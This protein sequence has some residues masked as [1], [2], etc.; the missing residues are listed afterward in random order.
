[1]DNKQIYNSENGNPWIGLDSYKE[2]QTLYGRSR[3]IQDLSMA[4]FY[5]R[6]TVVYG[7]SG[8][9]K[10]SLLHAGIFPKAR[11]RGCLP[12]SIRFDHSA[13]I[14]YREQLIRSIADAVI[15]NGGELNDL[16]GKNTEPYS[17]WEFFH[18]YQLKRGEETI[19]PL[20]V[21]DQFEEIFTL[22]RNQQQVKDF[23]EELADL[24]ND[25][26]PAYLQ[27]TSEPIA[28]KSSGSLFDN[29]NIQISD[30]L[31]EQEMPFHLV[32]VLREDYLSYLERYSSRTPSLKQN[33]FGLL[34]ITYLQALEIITKPREGLVTNEVA[35]TIIRHIVTENDIT[36]ET[37]VDSA[38]LSL[39]LNRLYEKKNDA[40]AITRQLV[41]EYGNALLEDF[42]AEIAN[43]LDGRTIHYLEDT[44][45]NSDGHRENVSLES[46]YRYDYIK[47]PVIEVLEHNHLLRIFS[48]GNVQRVEFAH[49]VLCPIIVRRRNQRQYA[50]RTRRTKRVG[51]G[52]FFGLFLLLFGGMYIIAERL[53]QKEALA[54]QQERLSEMEVS[55][56]EKGTDKM[57]DN[58]DF[59]GAIR[60]LINSMG[61]DLSNPS[62]S[63][64]RKELEL[65]VA[66]YWALF[67]QDTCVA[68]V[69][70]QFSLPYEKTAVISSSKRL[71]GINDNTG[72]AVIIDSHTGAI[73][74][75]LSKH[76]VNPYDGVFAQ[77]NA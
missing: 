9:G 45:I 58:Y 54:R 17:L 34:P 42:Y 43:P 76:K 50:E 23:F 38:I 36:D 73:V 72:V 3:E 5:N 22:G 66:A 33:R 61:E 27:T 15:D 63:T 7:R 30:S 14:A 52:A 16:T 48:Y 21:I 41:S 20:I 31:Y 65:R 47:R 57:L 71:I 67:S 8:I 69:N 2:G 77:E 4:V 56:I 60:L 32:F 1:M 51:L 12:I 26:K 29:L 70:Y 18:Y 64:A 68:K 24:L 37:P 74:S 6:H 35:D 49:D 25:I 55:L 53:D 10:S 11:R 75:S 46:L 13:K 28:Q 40:P 39:F 62:L 44:L 59:Y 19:T